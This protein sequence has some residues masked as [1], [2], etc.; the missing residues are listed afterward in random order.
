M[1]MYAAISI[2]MLVCPNHEMTM[3]TS[4][5]IALKYWIILIA[6]SLFAVTAGCISNTS[7]QTET[8][9]SGITS[10]TSTPLVT[11][12]IPVTHTKEPT[13][14]STVKPTTTPTQTSTWTPTLTVTPT[15][16]LTPPATLEPELAKAEVKR[17][18]KEEVNCGKACFWGIVPGETSLGEA[19]NILKQLGISWQ[20]IYDKE[21]MEVYSTR[22]GGLDSARGTLELYTQNGVVENIRFGFQVWKS[23]GKIIPHS[24]WLAYSPETILKRYGKP[25]KVEFGIDYPHEPGAP[26]GSVWYYLQMYFDQE[27]LIVDYYGGPSITKER[28]KA[29]PKGDTFI[30]GIM[31]WIGKDPEY[32]P[33]PAIPLEDATGLTMDEFYQLMVNGNPYTCI[34]LIT[35]AFEVNP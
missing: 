33:G 31:V 13:A 2:H 12:T 29:C 3:K 26:P 11:Q 23:N 1:P 4:K 20:A 28:I 9:E 10:T 35:E 19:T 14:T 24:E 27:D 6:V 22:V 5:N 30:D 7:P 25:T 32:P 17:L 21:D 15:V 8:N 16:T 34:N 18:F